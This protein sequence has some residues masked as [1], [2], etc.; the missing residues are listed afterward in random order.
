MNQKRTCGSESAHKHAFRVF[1]TLIEPKSRS[2]KRG[3]LGRGQRFWP[4]QN[5][6]WFLNFPPDPS[7]LVCN[8]TGRLASHARGAPVSTTKQMPRATERPIMSQKH[9][10]VIVG[11][12]FAG[13]YAALEFEKS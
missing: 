12:G 11:G 8:K 2:E 3:H 7:I 13:L 10:I 5:I 1:S 9:K 6:G 4:D